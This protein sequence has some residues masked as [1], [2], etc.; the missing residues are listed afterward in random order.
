MYPCLSEEPL[1]YKK[2]GGKLYP[3]DAD[4]LADESDL[5]SIVASLLDIPLD[6]SEYPGVLEAYDELGYFPSL[7]V[8]EEEE[9]KDEEEKENKS[10]IPNEP[11]EDG[12]DERVPKCSTKKEDV[13]SKINGGGDLDIDEESLLTDDCDTIMRAEPRR[14]RAPK[15]LEIKYD[16][17]SELSEGDIEEVEDDIGLSDDGEHSDEDE[18]LNIVKDAIKDGEVNENGDL[19]GLVVSDDSDAIEWSTDED[20][21]LKAMNR[22]LKRRKVEKKNGSKRGTPKRKSPKRK[23]NAMLFDEEEE[24][25]EADEAERKLDGKR[26]SELVERI[27][28]FLMRWHSTQKLSGVTLEIMSKAFRLEANRIEQNPDFPR[29]KKMDGEAWEWMRTICDLVTQFHL[30]NKEFV[31]KKEEMHHYIDFLEDDKEMKDVQN[32]VRENS[33]KRKRSQERKTPTRN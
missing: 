12:D 16:P 7:E 25:E 32:I 21:E 33:R 9:E 15:K 19:A 6:I 26:I 29:V 8:D 20:D 3:T 11:E 31:S 27:H 5:S 28:D 4:N 13:D 2:R 23:Q 18:G 30:L 22:S 1:F 17:I 10:V 14:R 24:E